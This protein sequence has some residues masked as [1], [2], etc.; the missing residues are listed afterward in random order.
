[1]VQNDKLV[2]ILLG[3]FYL[4]LACISSSN[5]EFIFG[6]DALIYM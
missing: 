2:Q 1:M 6:K 3:S 5:F 4:H